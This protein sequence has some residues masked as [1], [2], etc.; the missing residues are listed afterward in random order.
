MAEVTGAAWS[1][2]LLINAH[3]FTHFEIIAVDVGQEEIVFI[4]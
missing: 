4:L 3:I 1:K 2:T